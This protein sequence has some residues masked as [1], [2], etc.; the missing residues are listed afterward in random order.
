MTNVLKMSKVNVKCP[1]LG[2]DYETGS[3]DAAIAAALLT[4]HSKTHTSAPGNSS[5]HSKPPPVERPKVVANCARADWMIFKS[6][7]NSFKQA[8]SVHS[9]K[10]VY[11]LIGCLDQDLA[12]L[13]YNENESPETLNEDNLLRLIERVAAKPENIWLTRDNLHSMTQDSGE[14]GK[15]SPVSLPG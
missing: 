3:Y 10:V 2:C 7:W 6:K 14:S 15:L 13:L 8:A 4:C 11:Q 5:N 12:T 9:S 1:V